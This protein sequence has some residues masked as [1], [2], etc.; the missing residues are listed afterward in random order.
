M[1][2][3]TTFKDHKDTYNKDIDI[4]LEVESLISSVPDSQKNEFKNLIDNKIM[5]LLDKI[6]HPVAAE[7][8]FGM[9]ISYPVTYVRYKLVDFVEKWLPYFSA[10]ETIMNLTQDPDDLVSFRAMDICAKHKLEAALPYLS[11]II[12]DVRESVSY[13]KKPVGLG[14]QKVFKSLLDIFG[15]D[16][17]EDL[18]ML[19]NYFDEN[20][21][22]K[23]N[24]DYE[25]KIPQSLIEEF[26][27]TEEEG[28]V[29]IPGGFFEYGLNENEVP[30]KTFDWK[31][32]VPKQRV[33]LPPYFIDKYQVTN[34]E[35]DEFTEFV[36]E[37][38]HI[39]CHPSEPEDKQHRR[40]T[41]WDE[42]Y[43]DN[44]A[45]SGIDFYDAFAFARYKGKELPTEFQWEKAAR[46]DKG[47]IWPWG[48]KFDPSQVRY[49]G[50]LYKDADVKSLK[51]W[52]KTLLKA[53]QDKNLK[54]FTVDISDK[55]NVS[56]YGVVGMI[57][58][59]WEWTRSELK[60]KRNFHPNFKDAP[61]NPINNFAVLKGGSF[62]SHPGLMFP[63]Y[64]AKDIPFCRHNEMG[65]RCVKNIPIY[66]IAQSIKK[67]ITNKAV[68]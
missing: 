68:Y 38:G 44:H 5:N 67:P 49:S 47:N 14:A 2:S 9:C 64:R 29:L 54:A 22:L 56:P 31:D 11:G 30:D 37:Y 48:D 40:N 27:K 62:Y 43:L 23:N 61:F 6:E 59:T 8:I 20:G 28:M 66:K 18:I 32:A 58:G 63:S 7:N 1:S 21:I 34:K 36:E 53:D 42:R 25:E 65:I 52:R 15:V 13:P 41:Y 26:E 4:L 12:D 3:I 51:S 10:V 57:G 16:N 19:K 24:F 46:G 60:T 50:S 45:V 39:F 33:W 17:Q 55:T 35:Y